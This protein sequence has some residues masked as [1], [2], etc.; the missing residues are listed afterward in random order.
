MRRKMVE[1]LATLAVLSICVSAGA[2][3]MSEPPRQGQGNPSQAAAPTQSQQAPHIYQ[4]TAIRAVPGR[5]TE[6]LKLL[7]TAPSAGQPAGDFAVV[8]RHR[9]GHEWDFLVIQHVGASATVSVG[10]PSQGDSPFSQVAA[11]HGDTYAAGPSLD[12]FRRASQHST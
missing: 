5:S 3:S 8:F 10:P 7:T 2:G 9:E 12:E 1:G 4:V 11:W 6:L